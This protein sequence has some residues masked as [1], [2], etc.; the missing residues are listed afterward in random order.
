MDV[1]D[2]MMYNFSLDVLLCG[3]GCDKLC[4]W[5]VHFSVWQLQCLLQHLGSWHHQSGEGTPERDASKEDISWCHHPSWSPP[6]SCSCHPQ[7]RQ[8][9]T[10]K[11]LV[12]SDMSKYKQLSYQPSSL[13]CHIKSFL[14]KI[15][16]KVIH[17]NVSDLHGLLLLVVLN[18]RGV[19]DHQ[20]TCI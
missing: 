13:R 19:V 6:T 17:P 18:V 7:C 11:T 15:P 20:L 9:P 14:K 1:G 5:L 12:L 8:P 16:T 2:I 4:W 10:Y 3:R